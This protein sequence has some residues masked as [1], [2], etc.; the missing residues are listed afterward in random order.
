MTDRKRPK[1]A[2]AILDCQSSANAVEEH[3]PS[4]IPPG[5]IN[6]EV[7]DHIGS[8]LRALYNKVVDEPV[9]ERFLNLL[10]ALKKGEEVKK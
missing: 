6:E 7:R 2:R 3:S 8:R 9:P 10:E 4:G 5:K 1:K